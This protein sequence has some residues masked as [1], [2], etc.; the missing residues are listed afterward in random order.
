MKKVKVVFEVDEKVLE[1]LLKTGAK[2]RKKITPKELKEISK[3]DL[4]HASDY[5]TLEDQEMAI[6]SIAKVISKAASKAS[7]K[8]SNK[9]VQSVAITEVV[10]KTASFV[11]SREGMTRS[12]QKPKK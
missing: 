4:V 12:T 9:T 2:T 8:M 6:G 7:S 1:E 5:L 11:T 3:K 10:D